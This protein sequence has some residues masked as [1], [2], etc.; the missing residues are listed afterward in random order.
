M[1]L[2]HHGIHSNAG[3]LE[4]DKK[5]I[6]Q[7]YAQFNPFFP[8]I[9]C[10]NVSRVHRENFRNDLMTLERHGIHSFA[11]ALERGINQIH[12]R[13]NPFFPSIRCPK[14]ILSESEFPEFEN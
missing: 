4:R 1:T 6:N 13:L 11:V 2:E 3:A 7:I 5:R 9:R 14:V 10:T 8:S 12:V